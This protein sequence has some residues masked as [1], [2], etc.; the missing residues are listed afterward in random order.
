[1]LI[2]KAVSAITSITQVR[3]AAFAVLFLDA[4]YLYDKHVAQGGVEDVIQKLRKQRGAYITGYGMFLCLVFNRLVDLQSQIAKYREIMK[5]HGLTTLPD[6]GGV[7]EGK[8]V[9]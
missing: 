3:Y 7:I 8:K 2:L 4:W 1:M 5:A 9:D 6:S